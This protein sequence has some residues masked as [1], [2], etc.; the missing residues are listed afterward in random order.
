MNS[1]DI[2]WASI[3]SI[4]TI[5]ILQNFIFKKG[6]NN[7]LDVTN[8]KEFHAPTSKITTEPLDLEIDFSNSNKTEKEKIDII[9]TKKAIYEFTNNGATINKLLIKDIIENKNEQIEI[10]TTALE[11]ENIPF[12]IALNGIESTPYYYDFLNYY[13]DDKNGSYH[14]S[15][16]SNTNIATIKKEFII[17]DDNYTIDL[18]VEIEPI[19]KDIDIKARIIFPA[20]LLLNKSTSKIKAV[21]FNNNSIIKKDITNIKNIGKEK[22]TIFGLETLYFAN[23]LIEDP[24]SFAQRAYYKIEN[25]GLI[26]ES[27]LET[28]KIKEK[29]SWNLKFYLGPKI[30]S[31]LL[32]VNS[33]LEQLLDY[34][35]LSYICKM[36]LYLL[37]LF[38]NYVHNYGIA[39]ILVTLFTKIITLPFTYQSL[40]SR[41]NTI[42]L[43]KNSNT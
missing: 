33:K 23:L 5:F 36:L 12:L 9:E 15:Y 24:N 41:N 28:E 7:S 31:E 25:N 19:K 16:I 6:D 29:R 18:N 4:F 13:K 20:P 34:G 42:E 26:A 17:Y 40:K 43:Q 22:P 32:K 8:D 14:I 2:V 39:I 35:W 3:I 11:K 30:S 1:K 38:Y 27:I 37:R 10:I 21:M